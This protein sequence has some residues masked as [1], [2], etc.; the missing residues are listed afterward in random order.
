MCIPQHLSIDYVSTP[1]IKLSTKNL[2]CFYIDYVVLNVLQAA[3]IIVLKLNYIKY[4]H[5]NFITAYKLAIATESMFDVKILIMALKSQQTLTE[6]ISSFPPT[7]CSAVA[8]LYLP[9]VSKGYTFILVLGMF[10]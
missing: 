8:E 9:G 2:R 3:V 10:V 6:L 7:P 5:Y 1:S 4:V